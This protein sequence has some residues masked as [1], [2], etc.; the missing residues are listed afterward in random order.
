M[1][2]EFAQRSLILRLVTGLPP[3]PLH[4]R[5]TRSSRGTTRNY[6]VPTINCLTTKLRAPYFHWSFR[7]VTSS[8]LLA[9]A[10]LRTVHLFRQGLPEQLDSRE[11][12]QSV[13][14][15][16]S[17]GGTNTCDS[18]SCSRKKYQHP[19]ATCRTETCPPPTPTNKETKKHEESKCYSLPL[20]PSLRNMDLRSAETKPTHSNHDN[21]N[22]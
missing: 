10:A 8:D 15:A 17:Q 7:A 9:G 2:T 19:D 16:C 21:L 3:T 6:E 12:N 22:P 18:A 14:C 4:M 20:Q 13:F 1:L 11:C 5:H